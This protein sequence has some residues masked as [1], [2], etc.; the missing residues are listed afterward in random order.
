MDRKAADGWMVAAVAVIIRF[1]FR[2]RILVLFMV[3]LPP[4]NPLR[5]GSCHASKFDGRQETDRRRLNSRRASVDLRRSLSGNVE[6]TGLVCVA[7][8][9]VCAIYSG[10]L[11]LKSARSCKGVVHK[12]L[13]AACALDASADVRSVRT[14][15][16]LNRVT[17]TLRSKPA[18]GLSTKRVPTATLGLDR[19]RE[20]GYWAS[21]PPER[22]HS[23]ASRLRYNRKASACSRVSKFDARQESKGRRLHG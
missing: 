3:A 8:T 21:M 9:A 5:S 1:T 15:R 7:S 20:V 19:Y 10:I 14:S 2:P 13:I 11:H 6:A 22:P 16:G 4:F 12:D 18:Q 23:L 17:K